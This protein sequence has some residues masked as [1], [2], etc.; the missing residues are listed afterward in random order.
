MSEIGYIPT[1]GSRC[2]SASGLPEFLEIEFGCTQVG[3]MVGQRVQINGVLYVVA[4]LYGLNGVRL[5]RTYL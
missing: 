2:T 4:T 5:Q 1:S 3:W